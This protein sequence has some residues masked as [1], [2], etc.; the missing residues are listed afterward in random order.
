MYYLCKAKSK[1]A[2]RCTEGES[3]ECRA[4]PNCENDSKGRAKEK[5]SEYKLRVFS[6]SH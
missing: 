4:V 2:K 3:H 5:Y 6:S 1:V